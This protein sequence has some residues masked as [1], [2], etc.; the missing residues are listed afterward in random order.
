[1]HH[2]IK[3]K[4]SGDSAPTIPDLSYLF[5]VSSQLHAP[6]TLPL[7]KELYETRLVQSKRGHEKKK[8]KPVPALSQTSTVHPVA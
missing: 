4:E 8:N 7:R 1:M 3:I 2:T 6:V 5:E